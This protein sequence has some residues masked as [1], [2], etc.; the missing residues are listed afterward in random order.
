MISVL[1]VL[2]QD[3]ICFGNISIKAHPYMALEMLLLLSSVP[4]ILIVGV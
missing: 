3:A 4:A 1:T 2:Q